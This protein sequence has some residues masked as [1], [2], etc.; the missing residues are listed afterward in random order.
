MLSLFKIWTVAIYEIKTLLRS[1]FFRIFSLLALIILIFLNVFFFVTRA[2]SFWTLRGIPSS[3]PYM[4]LLLLNVVQAIIGIFMASDFFKFDNKLDTTDVIYMRSMTN[5]DYV[6]GKTV[7]VFALF[8]SLN[9]LILILAFVFNF[10]FTDVP[11]VPISYLYYPLFISIPTLTFIFGLSFLSM[12]VLR[13]QAITFIVLLRD[14][15]ITLFILGI[16]FHYLFYYM[17]FNVPLMYSDFVGFG[18]ITSI[19]IHR[20]I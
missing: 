12:V 10:F 20:G 1:W 2:S 4:N 19:L 14:I 13:S 3:I 17:T 18:D 16:K 8:F 7:G 6:L 11:V 15:A 5:A 9:I